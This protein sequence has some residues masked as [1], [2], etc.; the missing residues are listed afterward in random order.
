MIGASRA[1][2]GRAYQV[3]S[4]TNITST[5]TQTYTIPS[6]VVFIEVEMYGAGGGGGVGAFTSSGKGGGAS[7]TNGQGGGGGAYVKHQIRIVDLRKDDTLTFTVGAGGDAGANSA[8][9]GSDG[10]D[11]QLTLHKRSSSTITTFSDII[12]GGGEGGR[13]ASAFGGGLRGEGGVAQ[14]GN[15]VNTDGGDATNRTANASSD[16]DGTAG[17][18]GADPDGGDGGSAAT[19]NGSFGA[20]ANA[21]DVPGGGGG[22]GASSVAPAGADGANGKVIVKAFG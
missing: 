4:T 13:S 14:N 6:G 21:G 20:A 19:S 15:L 17:G 5:G 12:A 22:G 11:T 3:L 9:F 10:G 7:H 18:A 16:L 1:A 8:D 2:S